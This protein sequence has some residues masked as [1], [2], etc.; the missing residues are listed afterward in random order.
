MKAESSGKPRKNFHRLACKRLGSLAILTTSL[1]QSYPN[2]KTLRFSPMPSVLRRPSIFRCAGVLIALLVTAGIAPRSAVAGCQS[3]HVFTLGGDERQA[4]LNT[5]AIFAD[6]SSERA[7]ANFLKSE[8]APAP[9]RKLPCSGPTCSNRPTQ[10]DKTFLPSTESIEQFCSTSASPPMIQ[11]PEPS[12][13]LESSAFPHS[14]HIS[15]G[16]ERPPR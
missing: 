10:P 2:H 6:S 11:A 16:L 4:V 9:S 13:R 14:S 7:T 1:P 5:L 15:F 12:D 3:P 8:P